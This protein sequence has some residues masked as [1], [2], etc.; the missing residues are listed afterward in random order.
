MTCHRGWNPQQTLAYVAEEFQIP[1]DEQDLYDPCSVTLCLITKEST[2]VNI[3]SFNGLEDGYRILMDC[4][5]KSFK[6][7]AKSQI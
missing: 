3:E 6:Q 2:F 4:Q 5:V 7:Q 1:S